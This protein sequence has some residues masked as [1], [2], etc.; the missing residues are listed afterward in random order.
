MIEAGRPLR[1]YE[2]SELSEMSKE[3]VRNNLKAM[4]SKGSILMKEA[5][6]YKYYY[7]QLFFLD[8]DVLKILYDIILPFLKEVDKNS[9]YSQLGID[10][11]EATLENIQMLLKLFQFDNNIKKEI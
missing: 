1:L 4:V 2:I 6:S 3:R 8:R 7:P 11:G 10:N 9:D 5:I